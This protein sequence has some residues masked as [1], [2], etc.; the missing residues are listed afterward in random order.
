[1]C[2]KINL[3]ELTELELMILNRDI[4]KEL[5]KRNVVKTRNKPIAGYA[6]WLIKNTFG[7]KQT[8]NPNEKYDFLDKDN[9]KYLVRSRQ[10]IG[11]KNLP[12]GIIRNLD[13]RNFDYLITVVFDEDFNIMES[14]KISYEVL[15]NEVDFNSYQ[16]GFILGVSHIS[17]LK[18]KVEDIKTLIKH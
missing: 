6:R 5:N 4:V 1:M 14:Y 8:V 2:N 12:F 11:N 7:F 13:D 10:I 9:N 15:Q 3:S 16:K 17:K 18:S